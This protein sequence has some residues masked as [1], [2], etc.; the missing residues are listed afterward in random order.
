MKLV[1]LSGR[2]RESL[3]FYLAMEEFVAENI[4]G[5][6]FFIWRVPPTVIAGRNQ[7]LHSEVDM[8]FCRRNGIK[9]FRRKSGCGCV[10][11]DHGNVM[12]SFVTDRARADKVFGNCIGELCGFLGSLG[13]PA[14]A[15]GRNDI[16]LDGKKV[17][18]NA[19]QMLPDRCVVHGTLLFDSDLTMM[20]SALTPSLS[21]LKCNGVASV[22][23]RVANIRPFLEKYGGDNAAVG[24]SLFE[25]SLADYFADSET[26]LDRRQEAE[27]EELEKGY[28]DESFISGKSLAGNILSEK[29][30]PGVGNISVSIVVKCGKVERICFNGDY[31]SDACIS[32]MLPEERFSSLLE[33]AEPDRKSFA[34]RLARDDIGKYIPG[35]TNDM[36]LDMIFN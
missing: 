29:R 1:R 4:A 16:F 30:I 19:F 22:R 2:P 36:L 15:T 6:S 24:I 14:E 11:D 27:I 20:E 28:L 18:G 25:K 33:G 34:L 26:V 17:C 10:Y 32:D 7:V 12:I 9:V 5:D 23:N 13:L 3:V 8:E 21:K 35:L 31:F